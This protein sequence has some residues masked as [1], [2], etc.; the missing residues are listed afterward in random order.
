[1]HM[2]EKIFTSMVLGIILW[3][4]VYTL[5]YSYLIWFRPEEYSKQLKKE[6][7]KWRLKPKS[8]VD[9]GSSPHAMSTARF[10]ASFVS[11]VYFPL[12]VLALWALISIWLG[13]VKVR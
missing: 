13:G 4:F 6:M 1:M 3:G 2:L 10:A 9:V 12:A 7:L 11:L 8:V 5:R